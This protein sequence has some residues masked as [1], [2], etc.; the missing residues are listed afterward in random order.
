M[1]ASKSDVLKRL[2]YGNKPFLSPPPRRGEGLG[3]IQSPGSV[4]STI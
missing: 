2:A 3:A 4:R 1:Q